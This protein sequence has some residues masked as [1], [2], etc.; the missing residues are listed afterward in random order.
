MPEQ[1]NTDLLTIG[2]FLEQDGSPSLD[3]MHVYLEVDT[4]N[5]H[6]IGRGVRDVFV[7]QEQDEE[8]IA[9]DHE[10]KVIVE[11]E[12]DKIVVRQVSTNPYER[13]YLEEFELNNLDKKEEFLQAVT[14]LAYKRVSFGGEKP[15]IRLLRKVFIGVAPSEPI[16]DAVIGDTLVIQ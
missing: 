5:Y 6:D 8:Y 9:K 15:Y 16:G 7:I 14:M 10:G 12:A 2:D 11:T 13:D 4:S 3:N 1:Y